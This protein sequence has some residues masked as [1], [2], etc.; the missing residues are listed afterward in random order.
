MEDGADEKS[1]KEGKE[2]ALVTNNNSLPTPTDLAGKLKYLYIHDNTLPKLIEDDATQRMLNLLE[3]KGT[4]TPSLRAS[5]MT[6]R[7]QAS[8]LK[9]IKCSKGHLYDPL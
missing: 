7:T 8:L 2:E 3:D 6:P 9:E 4:G 5:G 1:G